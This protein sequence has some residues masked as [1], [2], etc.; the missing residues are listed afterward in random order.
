MVQEKPLS[1][2]RIGD[3]S[4]YEIQIY[5]E[6]DARWTEWFNGVEITIKHSG[7]R[8]PSTTL[9][10]PTI[11][12]SKLRGILDKIWDMNINLISVRRVV[13]HTREDDPPQG[14]EI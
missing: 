2:S 12:Q 7:D 13:D 14:F 9:I 4:P 11:D 8:S 5:G 6:L 10:C 1:N 3:P